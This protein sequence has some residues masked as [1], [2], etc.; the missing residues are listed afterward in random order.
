M[1][2]TK[3]PSFID[4]LIPVIFLVFMLASSVALFGSDS[5]YGPNQIV[6]LLTAAIA[7]II[8]L[9]NGF[10]WQE[11]EEAMVKGI[12]MS[13][14]AIFILLA[15]GALIGTWLLSG[16]VPSLI[17]YGVQILSPSWFYAAACL[18]S[19]IVAISIGS[20]WT[21]AATV[22]V[23]LMG[24][25][26]G[27]GVDPAVTAGAVISGAYFGD[28]LS[29]LSET[30][31]LAPAVAGSELFEHIRHMLWST[32]PAFVLALIIFT[33]MG[34][35]IDVEAVS[36]N[37]GNVPEIIANQFDVSIIHLMPLAILLTMAIK[38]VPAFPAIFI[39]ALIG[40]VWGLVFQTELLTKIA[41]SESLVAQLSVVWT[42]LFSGFSITT[43]DAVMDDLLSGGGM[44]N[45]LNTVWLI[46]SALMFGAMMEKI[47][48]LEV[49]VKQILKAAKSTGALI[50]STIGTAFGTNLVTADQYI[51]IVMPGRMYKEEYQRR[52]LAN[53]NLSRALEDGGTITSPLI[54]WN[55]CGAY[56]AGVLLVSPLDY[57]PYALFNLF[58]P[59]IAIIFAFIGFK[60]LKAK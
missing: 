20:S 32:V 11:L 34:L 38:K 37:V 57:W 50:T 26:N 44:A 58:N 35:Q 31:N 46:M 49:F 15:V 9:K 10:K 8:G 22:G 55:T 47:G 45:M 23:A 4:A 2:T 33:V 3:Q 54:P 16:T 42:A 60:V 7:G 5:S 30:T 6:L 14:G 41:E 17:Y 52:G 18:L 25:A 40:G 12:S 19:A 27:L 24:I 48:L 36:V 1:Q 13:M 53:V 29:P 59:I 28:K 51:A 43:G 39:A 21:T 56:M